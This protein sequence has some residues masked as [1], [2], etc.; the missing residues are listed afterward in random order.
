[1]S[2]LTSK[3]AKSDSSYMNLSPR[4]LIPFLTRDL[5]HAACSGLCYPAMLM[6]ELCFGLTHGASLSSQDKMNT[7]GIGDVEA[8]MST[9]GKPPKIISEVKLR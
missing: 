9:A 7:L 2:G 4:L 6:R 1:M 3:R 5:H 8:E